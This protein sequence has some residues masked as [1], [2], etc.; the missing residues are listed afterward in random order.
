MQ[1]RVRI[2]TMIESVLHVHHISE[3]IKHLFIIQMDILT[4][5]L[6]K[7][8]LKKKSVYHRHYSGERLCRECLVDSMVKK[9]KKSISRYKM[10]EFDNR[11]AVGVSGGKDSLSLLHILKKIEDNFPKS[12]IIAISVDEGINAYRDEAIALA[13]D[14]T[15]KLEIEHIIISFKEIFGINMDEIVSSNLK[16]TPCSY[17]G[18]LRRRALDKVAKILNADRLATGHT[19]DD[20]V[21][22]VFINFFRGNIKGL[23]N[24]WPGGKKVDGFIRRVKPLCE[25][26][27]KESALYAFLNSIEFQSIICPYAE[28]SMRTDVRLFLNEMEY[29]HSGMLYSV[30]NTMLRII[31]TTKVTGNILVRSCKLCGE[32]TTSIICRVC[33][34]LNDIEI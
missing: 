28:E 34:L 25:I 4:A 20:M 12:E 24:F 30:M 23:S 26:P 13:K 2:C 29:K 10:F 14:Q 16:M 22:T 17:C 6:C 3:F 9:V 15:K 31:P 11:I 8:C 18:V 7:K 1:V 5:S 32:P 21:Q 27:E 33:E 19:L